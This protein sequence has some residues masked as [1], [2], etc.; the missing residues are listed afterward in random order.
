[1]GSAETRRAAAGHTKPWPHPRDAGRS[2]VGEWRMSPIVLGNH[3]RNPTSQVRRETGP[4][5]LGPSNP[6]PLS[7]ILDGQDLARKLACRP[8]NAHT[9]GRWPEIKLQTI[10]GF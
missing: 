9:S 3:K 1:M 10:K 8:S 6:H 7:G 4:P 2:R 5:R